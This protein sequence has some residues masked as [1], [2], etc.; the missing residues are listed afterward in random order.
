[1]PIFHWLGNCIASLTSRE[2]FQLLSLVVH[3]SAH[4]LH[5]PY[6]GP[7]PLRATFPLSTL[8]DFLCFN[9]SFVFSVLSSHLP[10]VI[11]F[12]F[13]TWGCLSSLY[14]KAQ[15]VPKNQLVMV[16]PTRL[17]LSEYMPQYEVL[18]MCRF[19]VSTLAVQNL[20]SCVPPF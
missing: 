9:L 10:A 13:D 6:H 8:V 2:D 17:A 1:M 18:D 15:L 20:C 14:Q 11:A 7:Q 16:L 19:V 3:R 4:F 12:P 5:F